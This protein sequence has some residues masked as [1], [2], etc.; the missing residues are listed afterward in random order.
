MVLV[1]RPDGGFFQCFQAFL[2]R[3]KAGLGARQQLGL[4]VEA[5]A[6]DQFEAVEVGAQHGAEI[7]F[8]LGAQPFQARRQYAAEP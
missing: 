8:Q 4:G 3:C 2:E 6:A 5:L 7:V 1:G